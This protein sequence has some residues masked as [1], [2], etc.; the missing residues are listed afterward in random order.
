VRS[1]TLDAAGN[2]DHAP[3]VLL[4]SLE[5]DEWHGGTNLA[6]IRDAKPFFADI[7]RQRRIAR[8]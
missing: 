7:A 5:I 1:Q 3:D 8:I 2:F 6:G 4:D